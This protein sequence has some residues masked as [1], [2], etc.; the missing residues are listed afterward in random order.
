MGTFASLASLPFLVVA[1]LYA[2]IKRLDPTQQDWI[3]SHAR[4][5]S[6]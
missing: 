6:R 2:I 5:R 1:S 3:I 4:F